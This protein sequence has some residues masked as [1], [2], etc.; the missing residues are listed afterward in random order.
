MLTSHIRALTRLYVLRFPL[1]TLYFSLLAFSFLLLS[2]C[3]PSP[4][5]TPPRQTPFPTLPLV[6]GSQTPDLVPTDVLVTPGAETPLP[7]VPPTAAPVPTTSAVAVDTLLPIVQLTVQDPELPVSQGQSIALNVLAADDNAIT[8]LE[9]YDNNTLYGQ[10]PVVVSAP[11]YSNQFIWH[12]DVLGKHT[13]RALAYDGAGNVSAPAQIDLAVINNNRA[14]EVQITAPQ[15]TK[16]AELGAPITIQGVATDDVAVTRVELVVDNQLLTFVKPDQ[17]GGVTP[18]A[19]A[20]PWTPTSTGAH[21]I[22]LR[23]Y[24]NQNQ[25]DDSLRYTIHVF[26]NQPAVVTAQSDTTTLAFGDALVVTA[27]ALSNNGVSRIELYV[28]ERLADAANSSSPSQQTSMQTA[29]SAPDLTVG[30]HTFF[31]RAYDVTGE[32]TDTPHTP[33]QVVAGTPHVIRETPVP[34]NTRTPLPPTPTA[35]PQLNIPAPPSIDLKLTNAPV[36]LPGTAKIQI[37]ASGS[38]ELD[39]V[40]LWVR[41]PGETSA[42]LVSEENVQGATEKTLT[43]DWSA[44]RAGVVE[45]YARVSDSLKQSRVSTPLT[46][47]VTAPP[48]PTPAPAVFN[49]AQTWFAES[50]AARYEATFTQIGRALRGTFLEIRTD[51]KILQGKI[52]SGAVTDKTAL[53]GVDFSTDPT[54]PQHSLEFDCTFNARPP[55]LTCNYTNENNERGSAVFQPLAP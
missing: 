2:A 37:T 12:A 11:V 14:P 34:Q 38:S 9:I 29:L 4:T 19:V 30:S 15:G 18:F 6:D 55:V 26:D 25:S 23:A 24:D 45:M 7:T 42:Q 32:T 54:A 3:V 16:D 1:L 28:D 20:L 49:F 41:A 47:S 53:F 40:E 5:A 33:I 35:T 52:V 17:P 46:F 43:Y 31:V 48:A 39:T 21:T 44:P 10:A 50:S 8:R 51:G 36:V 22:V 13:L 27:L